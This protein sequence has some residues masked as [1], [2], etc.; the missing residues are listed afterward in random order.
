MKILVQGLHI[1]ILSISKYQTLNVHLTNMKR[2]N[3]YMV[4]QWLIFLPL[5]LPLGIVAGAIEGVKR[6]FEQVS[7][8]IYEPRGEFLTP[9]N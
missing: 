5:I 9:E 8:D 6:I 3:S 1:L 7:S 2:L 4:V